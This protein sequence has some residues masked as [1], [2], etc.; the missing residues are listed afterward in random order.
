MATLVLLW[1]AEQKNIYTNS[2]YYTVEEIK[3]VIARYNGTNDAVTAYGER[4]YALYKVFEKYYK[5]ARES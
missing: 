4:N 2:Y 3:S 5:L 1:G